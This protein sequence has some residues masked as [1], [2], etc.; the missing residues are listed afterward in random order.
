MQ[1]YVLRD[2]HLLNA[3]VF[4]HGKAAQCLVPCLGSICEQVPDRLSV[5]E[6]LHRSGYKGGALSIQRTHG[7]GGDEAQFVE[8]ESEKI[9]VLL[10]LITKIL[11]FNVALGQHTAHER[12]AEEIVRRRH[13]GRIGARREH[14][15]RKSLYF[16][17]DLFHIKPC[18]LSALH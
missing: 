12:A 3:A 6:A 4:D 2:I 5:L 14:D 15:R 11:R 9:L 13:D 8:E 18:P 1:R 17:T 7:I 10:R 16:Y